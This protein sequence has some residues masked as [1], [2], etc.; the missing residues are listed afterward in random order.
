[1][2]NFKPE[3]I[4]NNTSEEWKKDFF[5]IF[6]SKDVIPDEIHVN[7]EKL[8][9]VK[10]K[11]RFA[12]YEDFLKELGHSDKMRPSLNGIKGV[13]YTKDIQPEKC[14]FMKASR[15]DGSEV[16]AVISKIFNTYAADFF[17]SAEYKGHSGNNDFNRSELLGNLFFAITGP[18]Y[19]KK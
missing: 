17:S 4:V 5:K 6:D 18:E 16:H 12:N 9:L 7:N 10:E 14:I 3:S 13:D 15:D 8:K 11:Y 19:P 1:M 2:P